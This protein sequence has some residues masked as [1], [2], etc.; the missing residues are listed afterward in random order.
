MYMQ[1]Y[2]NATAS[3]TVVNIMSQNRLG[4]NDLGVNQ[5]HVKA[6][7]GCLDTQLSSIQ[8]NYTMCNDWQPLPS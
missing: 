1:T 6:M 2:W 7:L 4:K 5:D 3:V 8:G